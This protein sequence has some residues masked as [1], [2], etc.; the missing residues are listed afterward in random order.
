MSSGLNS[1]LL[2][3]SIQGVLPIFSKEIGEVLIRDDFKFLG[4]CVFGSFGVVET[5]EDYGFQ[6][7]TKRLVFGMSL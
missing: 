4:V 2:V 6:V 7:V 1:Q 3:V 5:A